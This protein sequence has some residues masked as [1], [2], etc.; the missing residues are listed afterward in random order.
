MK[1]CQY[2]RS[3]N[4]SL[5]LLCNAI[6]FKEIDCVEMKLAF[7]RNLLKCNSDFDVS[8]TVQY[9]YCLAANNSSKSNV[10]ATK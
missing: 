1:N 6:F 10:G 4:I 2:F 3:D 9:E 7:V 8:G 5:E